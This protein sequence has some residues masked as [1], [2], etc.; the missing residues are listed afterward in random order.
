[1]KLLHGFIGEFLWQKSCVFHLSEAGKQ[2]KSCHKYVGKIASEKS[3]LHS[4]KYLIT[5]YP[6]EIY[7][8][9]LNR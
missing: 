3:S 6:P 5:S 8:H 2:E 7:S 4:Q 9:A 1:M